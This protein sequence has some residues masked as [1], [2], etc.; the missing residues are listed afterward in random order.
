M[1]DDGDM[2][3]TSAMAR[4]HAAVA[5]AKYQ[6]GTVSREQ[7]VGIGWSDHTIANQVLS[8]RWQRLMPG[9]YA[10]VTGEISMS[11]WMWAAHLYGGGDTALWS[12]SALAA[13]GLETMRLPIHLGVPAYRRVDLQEGIVEIHRFRLVRP[14]Q[15]F[16]SY[17]STVV[18]EHALLDATDSIQA[19]NRV[20]ALV[21]LACQRHKTTPDRVL[22]IVRQRRR[23]RHRRLI[24]AVLAEV[25]DGATSALEIPGVYRILRSHGLPS[26]RGQVRERQGNAVVLRD[27]VIEP[28]GLVIEFDGRLGHADPHGQL[29]DHRRDNAVI[30]SGRR[31]LRFGWTDVH[32]QACEAAAQVA[33]V[34]HLL[35]WT[36]EPSKC[37]P[38]CR[39][40][41][42]Q[43]GTFHS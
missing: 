5:M 9:V 27:R 20:T 28:F 8:S 38:S 33:G 41:L 16:A 39:V 37:S 24:E 32:D 21:T 34:L 2:V 26:G 30:A 10:T 43:G 22:R 14:A 11:A 29:R 15:A 4:H 36:G 17:P 31:V 35:G 13:H 7:L 6:A 23:V 25:R 40:N 12:W 1:A 19:A 18:L 3:Q 42:P